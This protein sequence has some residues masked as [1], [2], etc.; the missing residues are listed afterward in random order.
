[1]PDTLADRY[2]ALI[3]DLVAQTLKGKIASKAQVEQLLSQQVERGTGEMFERCLA[4]Q[5]VTTQARVDQPVNEAKQAKAMR[6]LRALG[7]VRSAWE[8]VQQ[9]LQAAGALDAAAAAV[10]AAEPGDRLVALA[11]ITDPNRADTPTADGL[12]CLAKTL[13][14]AAAEAEQSGTDSGDGAAELRSLA[15]GIRHGLTARDRLNAHLVSWMYEQARDNLGFSSAVSAGPWATWAKVSDSELLRGWFGALARGESPGQWLALHPDLST[16]DWVELVMALQGTWRGLIHWLDSQPY[17]PQ[18]GKRM[19]IA[20]AIAFAALWCQLSAG[21]AQIS[22][23]SETQR[24]RRS[25]LCF[26]MALQVL[27]AFAQK[28]YFPLYGGVFASFSGDYLQGALDYLD[29]PLAL[30]SDTR[31]KGRILT[32]LGYSQQAMGDS[33]RAIAFHTQALDIARQ[34][35]DQPTQIANQNHLSHSWINAGD[36]D[37]AIALAQQALVV[38]RAAGDRPGEAHALANLGT[39]EV[40]AARTE[41]IAGEERYAQAVTYLERAL[42]LAERAG[43]LHSRARCLSSLGLA[44]AALDDSETA[45]ATLNAAIAA[46]SVLGDLYLQALNY[47]TLA[48]AAL[49]VARHDEAIAAAA[50]GSWWFAQIGSE[51]WRQGARLLVLLQ[52]QLGEVAFA[53]ALARSHRARLAAIGPEG[54]EGLDDLLQTY[55]DSLDQA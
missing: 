16:A 33:G 10:L 19:S 55:R 45:V 41:G 26:Q 15:T 9:S 21:C 51:Q 53:E 12:V 46:G 39:A 44:Q 27:R 32:L 7:T 3:D 42:A 30:S 17:H 43:D 18:A 28:D 36:Y 8:A 6:S 14:R 31:E 29:R 52:G 11:T 37:Q 50:I 1:M 35:E 24:D 23:W 13:D 49:A 40:F 2:H 38:A 22:L 4:E 20:T 47:T 34:C 25:Q 5:T 54:C 48:G